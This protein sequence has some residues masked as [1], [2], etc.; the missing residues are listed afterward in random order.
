MQSR[1]QIGGSL[2]ADAPTYVLREADRELLEA[3]LAREYCYVLNSRQM[4]KSSLRVRAME[5]LQR[6]GIAC[7]EIELSGIGSQGITPQQWYGGIIQELIAGFGLSLDRRRWLKERE[8]LSPVQRL[9]EFIDTVLLEQIK[10]EIAIFIDEIDSVLG[11]NFAVDDFFALLRHLYNKR[12]TEPRYRRLTFAILGV[13]TPSDL[14]RDPRAAPFSIGRA[15]E[16]GGFSLEDC[17][18]LAKGLTGKAEDPQTAIAEILAWTGGQPF[19]TQKLCSLVMKV[20][21]PLAI[22]EEKQ[23]IAEIVRKQIIHNWEG[24]DEPEHLRTIRDRLLR[25]APSSRLLLRLYL[26]VLHQRQ[27]PSRYAYERVLLRLSGL[28]AQ[29]GSKLMVKNRIYRQVFNRRWVARQ[30]AE[31]EPLPFKK[32]ALIA[33]CVAIAVITLRFLGVWQGMELRTFDA[34]VRQF[35]YE[36]RDERLLIVGADEQDLHLYQHP[37]PDEILALA[38]KRLESYDPHIMGLDIVRDLPQP[39][40][41]EDLKQQLAKN[42]GLISV[43]ALGEVGN[44]GIAPPVSVPQDR[45][46]FADL[47]DDAVYRRQD[48]TVRRY[49]LSRSPNSETED[50]RESE[51]LA[52]APRACKTNFSLGFLLAYGYLNQEG[53]QVSV[54]ENQDWQLG[55]RV[56]PRL[57][58]RSGGYQGLDA[59]GNQILLRYRHLRDPSAIARQ[60]TVR[61]LLNGRVEPEWVKDR[62]VLIGVTAESVQD[63]HD[64]PYGRIRG[65]YVHAHLVS[66]LLTIAEDEEN[67]H[68]PFLLWWW[69]WWGDGLWIWGWSLAGG[70]GIY[71]WRQP[72]ERLLA[73]SGGTIL[74][75]GSCWLALFWGGWLPLVPSVIAS[76]LTWVTLLGIGQS[77][78]FPLPSLVMGQRMTTSHRY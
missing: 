16:L 59:R 18:P 7:T 39:P 75:Y 17:A 15:I 54:N 22:G 40:G 34:L 25:N 1:Y 57:E 36:T 47:Y 78:K 76:V 49:L 48:Y 8:D 20:S 33:S 26:R 72:R 4:G 74:L 6:R 45:I 31:L 2:P 67:W 53:I 29:Q 27:I 12:A 10:T 70:Y 42:E 43:C 50:L 63:P 66:Q 61:D 23:R 32:V 11:L 38:L 14:I 30:L 41:T 68:R 62:V 46:G 60:V 19:L 52:R 65:I 28:V 58:S 55:S 44:G 64:T 37:L 24:Q 71:R 21:R 73:L 13:A 35:P 56:V 3:L 77:Q 9:A 5:Q 69:P 51:T